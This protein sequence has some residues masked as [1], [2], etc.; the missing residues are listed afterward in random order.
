M[1]IQLI[2]DYSDTY[3]PGITLV[4]YVW[5]RS[6]VPKKFNFLYSYFIIALLTFAYSNYLAEKK[7]YNLFLYHFFIVFDFYAY[8]FLVFHI[9]ESNKKRRYIIYGACFFLVFLIF[10]YTFWENLSRINRIGFVTSGLL[11]SL[12]SILFFIELIESDLPIDIKSN[13]SFWLVAGFFVYAT[14]CFFVFYF[15]DQ[16]YFKSQKIKN[17]LWLIQDVALIIKYTFI[18]KALLCQRKNLRPPG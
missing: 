13:F 18:V 17:I 5:R 2:L 1:N 14:S 8:S 9:L 6:Y 12:Y 15:Y 11:L 3:A 10:D 16:G 7:C 4:M